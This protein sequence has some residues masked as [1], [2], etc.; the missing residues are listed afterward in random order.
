MIGENEIAGVFLP[1]ALVTGV[2]ALVTAL[3]LR[4]VLRAHGAY[5][6]VWHAGLFDVASLAVIWSLVAYFSSTF[7]Q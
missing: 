3:I 4:R 6:F 5:A 7:N 1:A 2:V